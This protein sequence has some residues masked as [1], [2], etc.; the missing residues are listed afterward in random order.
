[1]KTT[2]L[3]LSRR[4]APKVKIETE[5]SWYKE[6]YHN[7]FFIE[8]SG[9]CEPCDDYYFLYDKEYGEIPAYTTDEL[10]EWLPIRNKYWKIP[11]KFSNDWWLRIEQCFVDGQKGYMV[12]YYGDSNDIKVLDDDI[13]SNFLPEA[14]GLLAEYLVDNGIY[15]GKE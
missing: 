3:E 10:M 9:G 8:K 13:R 6:R 7:S 2:S 4:L 12:N 14:L 5:Y 11:E 1:M 15:K